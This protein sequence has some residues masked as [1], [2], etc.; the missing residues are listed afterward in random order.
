MRENASSAW[1][2]FDSLV[3][4]AHRPG[5]MREVDFAEYLADMY[6][7]AGVTGAVVIPNNAVPL[8]GQRAQ[9][10]HWMESRHARVAVLSDSILVRGA[11]TALS[12]FDLPIH[13]FAPHYT[14]D[15]LK[16]VALPVQRW[17]AAKL[18]LA[19]LLKGLEIHWPAS[20]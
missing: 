10:Q 14:D 11:V 8:P 18:A 6:T 20:L 13:A 16:Y 7:K 3:F 4:I 17:A 12:W 19:S 1:T 15:A 5:R 2:Y 9:I